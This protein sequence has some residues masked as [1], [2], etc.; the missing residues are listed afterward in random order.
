MS[1]QK[2]MVRYS[3]HFVDEQLT[4]VQKKLLD[5]E[6]NLS[7]FKGNEQIVDIDV[8]TQ[9][10]LN[11]QSTLEAEKLQ[12]DLLLSN[13]KHKAEAMKVELQTSGYFDPTLLDPSV[14]NQGTSPFSDLMSHLDSS[15][16]TSPFKRQYLTFKMDHA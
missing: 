10:L 14:E 8:N 12:N 7:T 4:E 11:Y 3:F 5:A 9:E 6:R 15:E 13:Y 16:Y 1:Q 2:Q